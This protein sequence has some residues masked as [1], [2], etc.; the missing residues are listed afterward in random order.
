MNFD[1]AF[2]KLIG[3]EGGFSDD[4]RDPGGKTRYGVTEAVAREVGYRGD[5][6]A[7]PLDLAKRIYSERYWLAV[8]CNDLPDEIR[9]VVFDAAVNSGPKQS[10]VWLQRALGV[11]DDSVIGPQTL[12]AAA[13]MNPYQTRSRILAQRLKLMAALPTWPAFG[14]GWARRVA[15]LMEA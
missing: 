8:R 11:D 12:A 9:Y 7:L 14:R 15:D 3:Y 13:Q 10:I 1:E 6:A 2:S 5:M 4:A